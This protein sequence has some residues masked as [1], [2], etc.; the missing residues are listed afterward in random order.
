MSRTPS[1]P[2]I[3]SHKRGRGFF[4]MRENFSHFPLSHFQGPLWAVKGFNVVK[5][6]NI[7][8]HVCQGR[9]STSIVWP[10]NMWPCGHLFWSLK[11]TIPVTGSHSP[12]LPKRNKKQGLGAT[13]RCNLTSKVQLVFP[14]EASLDTGE[15]GRVCLFTGKWREH[16]IWLATLCPV[17]GEDWEMFNDFNCILTYLVVKPPSRNIVVWE[18]LNHETEILTL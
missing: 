8:N 12:H 15:H 17:V 5:A 13:E 9:V 4:S 14:Y 2:K 3:S 11:N 6:L 7:F 16:E 1:H 18:M 10:G